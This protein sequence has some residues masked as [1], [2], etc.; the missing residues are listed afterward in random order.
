M[1]EN[2]AKNMRILIMLLRDACTE[3]LDI[4]KYRLYSICP[5]RQI[6]DTKDE[7]SGGKKPY[8]F[9]LGCLPSITIGR[10]EVC[11]ASSNKEKHSKQCIGS[12]CK[13]ALG[14]LDLTWSNKLN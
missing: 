7:Q 2:S 14:V 12:S 13:T 1:A 4:P 11:V 5:Q 10:K 3:S 9:L 8:I 6:A